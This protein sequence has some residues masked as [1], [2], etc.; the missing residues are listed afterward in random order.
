MLQGLCQMPLPKFSDAN[1][2]YVTLTGIKVNFFTKYVDAEYDLWRLTTVGT[3]LF[4]IVKTIDNATEVMN[5]INEFINNPN[6]D[7]EDHAM[8]RLIRAAE[9][10]VATLQKLIKRVKD[11]TI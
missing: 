11:R 4:V 1:N 6:L 9:L 2:A 3:N 5:N 7:K 10:Q 8:V